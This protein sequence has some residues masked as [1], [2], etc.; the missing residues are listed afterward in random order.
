[1]A[2]S[3]APWAVLGDVLWCLG[4]G[5]LLAGVRDAVRLALGEGALRCFFRDIA[6]FAAAAVLVCGFAAGASAGGLARWYMSAALLLGA[7]CWHWTVQP[8]V[9]RCAAAAAAE[10]AK[11]QKSP[12][13][14]KN[15]LK[16]SCKNL[17]PYYIISYKWLCV[18]FWER[19]HPAM[20]KNKGR[21][22]RGFLPW[23]ITVPVFLIVC[24]SL[25]INLVQYQVS[26][27]SKQ[28]ELQ[29]VQNQL[30]TQLTENAELSGTLDQGESAI[31]ERYAREQGYAKP[32]ERVFVD[33]SGK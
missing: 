24:G 5:C 21:S 19:G 16:N 11:R 2:P 15:P 25:F 13:K 1:M 27:A 14:S 28:Q 18:H 23:W 10:S 9:H 8:A 22:Q 31:I 33:I 3:P 26:I 4:L 7:V 20:S 12:K 6:A 29:S 32:N 30:S 17:R